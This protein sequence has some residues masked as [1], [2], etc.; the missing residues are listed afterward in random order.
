M[1]LLAVFVVGFVLG[2]IAVIGL[3]ALGVLLV[4]S[5]LTKRT[6][7]VEESPVD[8]K[9]V[10]HLQSLHFSFPKQGDIW[11]LESERVPKNWSEK[12]SKEQERKKFIDVSPVRRH[13]M[14]K[15]HWLTLTE[16]DGSYCNI[17]LKGCVIE[18]VSATHLPSRKWAKRFPIKLQSK[19]IIYKGNKTL[20]IYL[21][22]SWDKESWCNALR[23]ASCDDHIQLSWFSKLQEDF[24]TYLNTLH[25]GYPSFMKPHIGFYPEQT[26]KEN[27]MDGSSKV[28]LMWKKF[29]R[30]VSKA[31]T[32]N[33]KSTWTSFSGREDKRLNERCGAYQDSVSNTGSGRATPTLGLLH[34]RCTSLPYPGSQG[35]MSVVSDIDP[36]DRISVDEGTLCW[37]LLISRLF[38]DIKN[39]EMV[40]KFIQDKIQRTLSNMRRPSYVGEVICTNINLGNLPPHIHNIRVLPMDLSETWVF[41]VDI[42]YSGGVILDVE[43]RIEVHE[44]DIQKELAGR[45][46]E[47]SSVKDVSSFLMEEFEQ[48][49]D[50]LNLAAGKSDE[51]DQKSEED[52]KTDE[53]KISKNNGTSSAPNLKS[54]WKSI[55]NTVAKHVSQ[56]PISLRIKVASLHGTLRL[57]IKPP[58]SD[59]L[60][61][62]FTSMPEIEFNLESSVGEHRITSARI[63]MF[64]IN[65]FKASIR[66]TM[67]MPNCENV[68]IPFMVAEKDDW[69]PRKA[70]PFIWLNQDLA[71]P[72]FESRNQSLKP[73]QFEQTQTVA[74][75][76]SSDVVSNAAEIQ[77]KS[78]LMQDLTTPLLVAS[79]ED[80]E[81]YQVDSRDISM[82]GSPTRALT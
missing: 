48:L 49:G 54:K 61:F 81:E 44:L 11:V 21:D 29:A 76:S 14:I 40:R 12:I 34:P 68:W 9:D 41:E 19:S 45:N 31:T 28:R 65:R 62:C 35:Q 13:A 78:M 60:W 4:I 59:Q 58:P 56:V 7:K 66:E 32:D 23:C 71:P 2:A 24:K 73:A 47:S 6:Q 18:A 70:A 63:A 42:E 37:N 69:V 55:V 72:S 15:D 52:P 79:D 53:I 77:Q 82:N 17:S 50:Q 67:V 30:K 33:N 10:D 27:R 5:K 64:L 3:E 8:S 75:G 38:F 46:S 43:T 20:Y 39:S 80:R 36:D 74:S 51:L 1:P 16:S 26:D 25:E 22:T 57:H